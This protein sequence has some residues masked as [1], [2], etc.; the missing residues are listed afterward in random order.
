MNTIIKLILVALLFGCLLNV[1]YGYFQFVRLAGC[2]GFI[3]LAYQE[4]ENNNPIT[5]ILSALCAIL[6]NP[7]FKIHFTRQLWNKIDVSIAIG[8]LIWIV[9][10][11][12][13]QYGKRKEKSN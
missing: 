8:L 4:F 9:F 3:Y 10:D 5:G 12:Y 7:I 2:A 1:P 6:L 11:L 13:L